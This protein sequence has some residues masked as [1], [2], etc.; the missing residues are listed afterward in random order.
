MFELGVAAVARACWS[1]RQLLDVMVDFRSNVLNVTNPRVNPC[2]SS[3]ERLH[4]PRACP[5]M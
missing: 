5:H 4:R 2:S 3:I 1:Q